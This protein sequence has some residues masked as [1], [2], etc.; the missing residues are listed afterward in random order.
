LSATDAI[1]H[2][3]SLI[4]DPLRV[5]SWIDFSSQQE[6]M[7]LTHLACGQAIAWP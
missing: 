5:A 4:F 3:R 1:F 7:P 6:P 2:L